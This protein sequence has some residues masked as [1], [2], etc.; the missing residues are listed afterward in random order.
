MYNCKMGESEDTIEQIQPPAYGVSESK[1]Q[2][3]LFASI[4]FLGHLAICLVSSLLPVS[5]VRSS[6]VEDAKDESVVNP[7]SMPRNPC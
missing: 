5:V 7:H 6:L 3:N 2:S 1:M 4:F